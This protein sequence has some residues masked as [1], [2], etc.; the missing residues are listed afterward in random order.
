MKEIR[1]LPKD[2]LDSFW[3]NF[4][5]F[6]L[7]TIALIVSIL[8]LNL[9]TVNNIDYLFVAIMITISL[10]TLWSKINDRNLS[11]VH[12]DLNLSDNKKMIELLANNPKWIL[13]KRKKSYWEF[14]VTTI[15]EIPTHKLVIIAFDKEI[16]FNFRNIGSFRGRAPFSFGMDTYHGYRLKRKIINYVHQNI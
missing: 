3:E 15:F 8:R 6:S 4:I 1:K 10:Y 12:S 16:L 11:K 14:T 7:I 9:E 2:E 5:W 13:Q